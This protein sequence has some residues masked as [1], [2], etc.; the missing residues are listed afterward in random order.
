MKPKKTK[1][2]SMKQVARAY[3]RS[4]TPTKIDWDGATTFDS[5]GKRRAVGT[6]TPSKNNYKPRPT[7]ITLG[8]ERKG[9]GTTIKKKGRI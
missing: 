3:K 9:K 1:N 7:Q 4:H 8:G 2:P 6:T 5:N